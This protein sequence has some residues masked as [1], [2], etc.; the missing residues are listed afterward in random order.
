MLVELA[1]RDL[2]VLSELSLVFGPGMCAVTGETGAGKTLI[3]GAIDL[4]LGG[5][6]HADLVRPGAAEAVVEGR[7]LVDD[8]EVVLRRVVPAHGRSRAYVDDR[9]A[10]AATLGEW[11]ER[12]VDLHGQHDHQSLLRTAVQRSALDRY[13]RVDLGPLDAA[14]AELVGIERRLAELGGDLRARAREA[15]LYRFQVGEL[16]EAAIEDPDEDRR[17]E[18]EEELLAG[19]AG[20]REAAGRA[21]QALGADDGASDAVARALGLLE[22]RTPFDRVHDRL[23]G[24]QAELD[25]LGGELRALEE[26]LDDDPAR[27]D[28]LRARRQLLRDLMRKYGDTLEEVLAYQKEAVGRL[29]E[30][31]SHDE[32]VTELTSAREV[33]RAAEGDAAAEVGRARRRA[34]PELARAVEANLAELAMPNAHLE[35]VVGDDPGDDVTFLLAANPGIPPQPLA[36]AASGGELA[37]AMLGLRLVLSLGPPTLV[38]DEVDAGIGGSAARAVGSALATLARSRQVLVVTHLAQVAAFADAHVRVQK[39]DADGMTVAT[40]ELLDEPNR[41]S[42]ISRMLSGEPDQA[43]ARRHAQDLLAAATAQRERNG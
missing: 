11:G 42:E 18:A 40:A 29:A 7:F 26:S 1:V 14:R 37:R 22:G 10:T 34:A 12:L 35:V 36:R 3:V 24:V 31:E 28:A 2:G 5:R 8:E 9:L 6:A 27:L 16:A 25:D 32:L 30:L 23:R 21:R 33:A 13:G 39:V 4:L 15:D 17:L 38:F 41:I 19:A 20:N 43:S